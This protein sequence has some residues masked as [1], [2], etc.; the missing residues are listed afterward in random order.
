M[1]GAARRGSRNREACRRPWRPAA[2]SKTP[3]IDFRG[4]ELQAAD[5]VRARLRRDHAESRTG[6]CPVT[7]NG[8][9]RRRARSSRPPRRAQ[10]D[11]S[12][13]WSSP[14]ATMDDPYGRPASQSRTPRLAS[15]TSRSSV[16][17]LAGLDPFLPF[18]LRT[19]CANC[20]P[21]RRSIST[22]EFDPKANL[23]RSSPSPTWQWRSLGDLVPIRRDGPQTC[24]RRGALFQDSFAEPRIAS[25]SFAYSGS[26]NAARSARASAI[27]G[28]SGVGEKPSSAGASASCA[29]TGRP[30]D[31]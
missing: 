16:L 29:S 15:E 21:P 5:A 8:M 22:V 17:G 4:L 2:R 19:E 30:V 12:V 6:P 20:A 31:W 23:R 14:A 9:P 24:D 26:T 7:S 10:R 27:S 18:P 1:P 3:A 25:A 13:V 28:S 11:Q